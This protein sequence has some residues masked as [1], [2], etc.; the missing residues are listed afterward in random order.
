MRSEGSEE[1]FLADPSEHRVIEDP[2]VTERYYERELTGRQRALMLLR[3]VFE[4]VAKLLLFSAFLIPL[5]LTAIVTLD[6]P[7]TVF[8]GWFSDLPIPPSEFMS[9]GEGLLIISLLICL[10]LTRRWGAEETGRVITTSWAVTIIAVAMLLID[11]APQLSRTDFPSRRMAGVLVG[12]WLFA[13]MM[14]AQI[15]DYTRG[16]AWWRAPFFGAALGFAIQA[17]IYYPAAFIGTGSPWP[18][19]LASQLFLTTLIALA[20]T[21]V[22]GAIKGMIKPRLGLGGR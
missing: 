1:R 8:D 14:A 3:G 22:Y 21:V 12:S 6:L 11:L 4:T 10:L 13:Q 16:G 7:L 18:Y 20:F 9:R 5:H 15:Y 17:V 19:W 2:I